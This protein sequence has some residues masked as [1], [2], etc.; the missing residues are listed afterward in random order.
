MATTARKLATGEIAVFDEGD[1]KLY[2]LPANSNVPSDSS[3]LAAAV[4][5]GQA[6]VFDQSTLNSIS[7][8]L[9]KMVLLDAYG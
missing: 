2:L 9:S 8:A 6:R 4:E 1:R 5:G 3:G 7:Q